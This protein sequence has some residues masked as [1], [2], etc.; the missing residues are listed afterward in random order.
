MP[1]ATVAAI[2]TNAN[3]G[4]LEVLLT[5]RRIEPFRDQWCLPGGHIDEYELAKEAIVR[6]V[7]E[8]TGLDFEAS[9]FD[10]F[11]EIVPE[12]EIHAVVIVFEGYGVGKFNAQENEVSDIG[13][14]S[15]NE[16]R[17]L[18]L[19]FTHNTILDAYYDHI[20][21]ARIP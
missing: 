2:V 15:I 5:R 19:A 21:A 17:C 14:V 4:T 7:K 3:S 20:Q 18:P 11:D 6:E 8:E 16:A 13:W 9:F 10:Y 1:E 12:H